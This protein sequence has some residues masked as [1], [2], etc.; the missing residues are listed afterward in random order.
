M[1]TPTGAMTTPRT[2]SPAPLPKKTPHPPVQ[3]YPALAA[4]IASVLNLY[5]VKCAYMNMIPRSYA[6]DDACDKVG[7]P[8]P[9]LCILS[10]A[11]L[12]DKTRRGRWTFCKG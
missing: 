6:L 9:T 8:V 2:A 7:N 3:S 1:P 4:D 5:S 10:G 11:P 12:G